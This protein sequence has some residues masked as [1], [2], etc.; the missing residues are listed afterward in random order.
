MKHSVKR[1]LLIYFSLGK[2]GGKRNVIYC[3]W[4]SI[5]R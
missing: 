1:G 2:V 5:L 4:F 3:Y